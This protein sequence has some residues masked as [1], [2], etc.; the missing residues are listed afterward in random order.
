MKQK[1]VSLFIGAFAIVTG[2]RNVDRGW[3]EGPL[4][5][6]HPLQQGLA[7]NHGIGASALGDGQTDRRGVCPAALIE[8]GV[9]PD[10]LLILT[11]S[12]NH[13][14]DVAHIDSLSR[15]GRNGDQAH[16]RGACQA[17]PRSHIHR[18]AILADRAARKTA[19]G[20]FHGVHQGAQGDSTRGHAR[21]IGFDAHLFRTPADDEGQAHIIDLGDFGAQLFCKI[22]KGLITPLSRRTGFWRKGQNDGGHIINAVRDNQG[23]W[24]ARRYLVGVGPDF[25]VDADNGRVGID[26]NLE[27]R[28]DHE[29]VVID[30]GVDMIHVGDAFDDGFERL[31]G[32]F[33]RVGGM[34]AR[35]LD[36]DV[37][38]GDADLRLF[39]ARNG[40]HG[41][42]PHRQSRDQKERG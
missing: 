31:G 21:W 3:N 17:L 24:D 5:S 7:D 1:L 18:S 33:D 42:K 20:L 41:Q 4:Q 9:A 8:M 2:D 12:L 26:A 11:R 6:V 29:V 13:I 32:Q 10:P 30:K 14:G 15:N 19:S 39:L 16:F 36:H 38:H 22:I 28:G 37:D 34:D 25:F 27:P 23:F 40:R 35:R